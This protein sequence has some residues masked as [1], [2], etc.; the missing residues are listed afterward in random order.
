MEHWA[1]IIREVAQSPLGF[2]ALITLVISTIAITF[3]R[4]AS[5]R[6]RLFVFLLLLLSAGGMVTVVVSKAN[7]LRGI[8]S[9]DREL[10]E[11]IPSGRGLER[12][13][14]L[15]KAGDYEQAFPL[16]EQLAEQGN[17]IAMFYV[18]RFY[19]KGHHV[20]RNEDEARIWFTRAYT[21]LKK[22]AE[23]GNVPEMYYLGRMYRNGYGTAKD[24]DEA[25]SWYI[26][27]AD[28]GYTRAI[29]RI[30]E[31]YQSKQDYD[32]A[33]AWYRK[34]AAAGDHQAQS[35]IEE[36]LNLNTKDLG[37]E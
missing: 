37:S 4:S 12:A 26:K 30:G 35:K 27:A 36:I 1:E 32:N 2:I 20:R 10:D 5:T 33:L 31:I 16:F 19:R 3:F 21:K 13:H 28:N 7:L 15:Y 11:K 24:Y 22:L 18:G 34:A 9:E 8:A 29:Y 6:I 14:D 25:I 23:Q 17:A